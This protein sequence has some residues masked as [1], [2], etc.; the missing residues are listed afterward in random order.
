MEIRGTF[1]I[2]KNKYI[3]YIE[4]GPLQIKNIAL[5][6][7]SAESKFAKRIPI[8]I[9]T[10]THRE[11]IEDWLLKLQWHLVKQGC[12]KC[13]QTGS[14]NTRNGTRGNIR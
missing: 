2:G 7:H 5:L 1:E 14:G 4:K 10:S 12:K 13:S 6:E 3:I 11:V 9:S 8:K